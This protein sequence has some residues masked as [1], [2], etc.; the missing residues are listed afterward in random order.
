MDSANS[1]YVDHQNWLYGPPGWTEEL[2]L[3][4]LLSSSLTSV[5]RVD[6]SFGRLENMGSDTAS[7]LLDVLPEGNLEDRQNLGPTC[8]CL[9]RA[10][11]DHPGEVVVHGYLVSAPRWDERVTID[12][13]SIAAGVVPDL[14]PEHAMTL[15]DDAGAPSPVKWRTRQWVWERVRDHLGLDS[16]RSA[17]DELEL[18][19]FDRQTHRLGWWLWWD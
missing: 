9:L 2:G 18:M 14:T 4:D 7:H 11:V 8:Q 15:R 5:L 12:A 16:A 19:V 17:P 13:V 1:A 3:H 10:A 6:P